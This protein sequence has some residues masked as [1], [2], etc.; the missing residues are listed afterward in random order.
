MIKLLPNF[1]K[2]Y[3]NKYAVIIQ[4]YCN[5]NLKQSQLNLE[6]IFY[7]NSTINNYLRINLNNNTAGKSISEKLAMF[8]AKHKIL[9]HWIGVIPGSNAVLNIA[10]QLQVLY[11]ESI[12]KIL[13]NF[14][15]KD[16]AI[17]LLNT[18]NCLSLSNLLPWRDYKY[19]A[20]GR[21]YIAVVCGC[22]LIFSAILFG[23]R[24]YYQTIIAQQLVINKKYKQQIN[25]YNKQ[26]LA[27]WQK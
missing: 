2:K 16:L 26:S 11:P 25:A 18:P 10:Q 6:L 14:S 3:S 13:T 22:L 24:N 27:I 21:L 8:L 1:D 12:I 4:Q 20:I 7:K 19:K 5:N 17:Y 9:I 23:V 15:Y